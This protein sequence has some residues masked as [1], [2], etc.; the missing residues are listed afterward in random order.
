[1]IQ[2]G[3]IDLETEPWPS[4]SNAAKDL[5]QKMLTINPK[6]RPSANAIIDHPWFKE[7]KTALKIPL[8]TIQRLAIA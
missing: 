5:V 6:T 8:L 4:V 1:M 7:K 2:G 3:E